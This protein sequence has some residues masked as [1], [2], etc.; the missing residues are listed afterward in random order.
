MVATISSD[1]SLRK[2]LVSFYIENKENHLD[3]KIAVL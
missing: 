2:S 3:K 1:E